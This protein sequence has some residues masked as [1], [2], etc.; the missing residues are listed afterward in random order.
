ML[1]PPQMDVRFAKFETRTLADVMKTAHAVP[2]HA[3]LWIARTLCDALDRLHA[4]IDERAAFSQ[5]DLAPA[6]VRLTRGGHVEL[7]DGDVLPLAYMA[8]ETLRG[9]PLDMRVDLYGVG[10]LTWE[11][12]A[13]RPV[14]AGEDHEVM[15]AVLGATVPPPSRFRADLTPEVDRV[16]MRALARDRE[17]RPSS[18]ALLR[19]ELDTVMKCVCVAASSSALARW[20]AAPALAPLWSERPAL[21]VPDELPTLRYARGR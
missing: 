5:R 21:D 10:V 16:V 17:A 19:R 13:G 1:Q 11:L 20:L 7:S 9:T 18:A 6:S 8:P 12:L 14:F 4:R 3:A 2:V 15:S